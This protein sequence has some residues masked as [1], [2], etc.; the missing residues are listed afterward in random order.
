M[1]FGRP[2]F[3]MGAPGTAM[4]GV[5]AAAP[6]MPAQLPPS[7]LVNLDMDAGPGLVNIDMGGPYAPGMEQME[8]GAHYAPKVHVVVRGD[9]V[10]K[11]SRKYNIS[12]QA[13]I[14]ANNL[15]YPDV[16]YPGQRLVIP[17]GLSYGC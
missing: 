7:G 9:T 17:D 10:W 5:P 11:L 12:M 14:Q 6:G 8:A 16:L 3:P 4:P 13:I 2:T 1:F 15:R